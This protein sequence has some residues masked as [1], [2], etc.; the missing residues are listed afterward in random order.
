M[1]VTAI[2]Q[3]RMGSS[4]LPGKVLK[5]VLNRPLLEYQIERI[6]RAALIDDIVIATTTNAIDKPIVELSKRLSL[7]YYCGSEND[8]LSR[9]YEAAKIS[10]AETV[11]RLT[12]DCPIIDYRVIDKVIKCYL[13]SNG[14]YDYVSNTLQRTYPRGM[15][16]EVFS[17]SSLEKAYL[18]SS[19][20]YER[21]HV[22]PFIYLNP[23]RFNLANITYTENQKQ[24][25][26]TVDTPEDFLLIS[27]IIEKLYP[28]KPDF[29][30]EDT[31]S[32]LNTFPE[33]SLLNARIEQKEIMNETD[34]KS[35]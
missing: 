14:Q 23:D 19:L 28:A 17:A 33:W 8:V 18:E 4:R 12:S 16:I 15:D 9:Y 7:T 30:L 1:K 32:L 31:L 24:H 11:V 27:K 26:W 22:T 35:K 29:S 5:K 10:N 3:A 25:R 6:K 13:D 20:D 2:I 34:N 21:E